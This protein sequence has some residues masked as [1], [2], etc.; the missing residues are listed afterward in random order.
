[1]TSSRRLI[2]MRS[3]SNSAVS[4]N[5]L[6][7]TLSDDE[8]DDN[9]NPNDHELADALR[10]SGLSLKSSKSKDYQKGKRRAFF[11]NT[12]FKR[13][14]LHTFRKAGGN[15]KSS[16]GRTSILLD[17]NLSSMTASTR[18]ETSTSHYNHTLNYVE[19]VSVPPPATLRRTTEIVL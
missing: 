5:A 9:G 19:P 16:K 6:F 4:N 17:K 7:D 11:R 18:D 14:G 2:R 1:V 15:F 10:T 13:P 12:G 3:G 8:G